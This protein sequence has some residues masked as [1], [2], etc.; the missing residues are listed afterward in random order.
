MDWRVSG[1]YLESCNCDAICPCRDINGIPGGR[2]THGICL[3]V[4]NWLVVD[5]HADETDLSG[6]A[7]TLATR[8]SDDE[9]GSPW[10][11]I[12]YL[13]DRG[14]AEQHRMLEEIWTGRAA[15]DHISQL[16]WARR[17]RRSRSNTRRVGD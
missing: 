16:P 14:T 10:S 7:V 15:G 8:Y 17:R 12:L 6:L 9:E 11:W 5:G 2:S 13:D 3:G 1:T 4:L